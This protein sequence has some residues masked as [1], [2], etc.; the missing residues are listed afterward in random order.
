VNI[1]ISSEPELL[2]LAQRMDSTALAQIYDAYSPDIYRYAMRLLGNVPQAEDCVAETFSRLLQAL[3]SGKGPRDYL[4]AYLYRIAHNWITDQYRR[5]RPTDELNESMRSDEDA[6]EE[7]A[8]Q[9]A[10]RVRLLRA[11]QRLTPDQ[12]QVIALKFWHE[13]DNEE[14][15][16][17]IGKPV[18]A[19]KSL[20]HRALA[21]LE[22]YLQEE[23][24]HDHE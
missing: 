7:T 9:S 6:P 21:T 15:A 4:R 20:Q 16:R 13:W 8:E 18:G 24:D 19:I 23:E 2:K 10:Q 3:S 17:T 5:E 11:I 1:K 12:R 22:R 14:I